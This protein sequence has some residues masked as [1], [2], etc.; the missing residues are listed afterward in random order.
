MNLYGFLLQLIHI[1]LRQVCEKYQL[2]GIVELPKDMGWIIA[3]R[4]A[5]RQLRELFATVQRG[6]GHKEVV[7]YPE[8]CI[9]FAKP[10]AT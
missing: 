2:F 1:T 3:R 10:S 8:V 9:D 7:A 5:L 6:T 4:L